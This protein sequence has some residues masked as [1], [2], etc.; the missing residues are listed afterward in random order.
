M[1]DLIQKIHDVLKSTH[2]GGPDD[3]V[4]VSDGGDD[5]LHLVVVS[6]KLDGMRWQEKHDFIWN[7]L[8]AH[9]TPD[10]WGQIS[11]TIATTPEE[12]KAS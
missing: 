10:E 6:R 12:I 3:L 7:V 8:T 11:L 2:F 1:N 5:S 9:L 4:D